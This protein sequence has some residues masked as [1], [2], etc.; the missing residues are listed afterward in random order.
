MV[1][2]DITIVANNNEPSKDKNLYQ[3]LVKRSMMTEHIKRTHTKYGT[4]LDSKIKLSKMFV[5]F[6]HRNPE[7]VDNYYF[8][9]KYYEK[10]YNE[11][12]NNLEWQDH[13][14]KKMREHI[15]YQLS[16]TYHLYPINKVLSK[17]FIQR[18]YECFVTKNNSKWGQLKDKGAT[19]G[20]QT[21]RDYFF[22]LY[23]KFIKKLRN[24]N[25]KV[26]E[27][28]K[29]M[30]PL[31]IKNLIKEDITSYELDISGPLKLPKM[32]PKELAELFVKRNPDLNVSVED[33]YEVYRQVSVLNNKEFRVEG[34]KSDNQDQDQCKP[35]ARIGK[36]IK[37]LKRKWTEAK[38]K[39]DELE[40]YNRMYKP[41][42]L[43]GDTTQEEDTIEKDPL[44]GEPEQYSGAESVKENDEIDG[45]KPVEKGVENKSKTWDRN[46]RGFLTAW[47]MIAKYVKDH[48]NC[49]ELK[50][51]KL[52]KHF[53][54][55]H[56]FVAGL[57]TSFFWL[58]LTDFH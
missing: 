12:K 28:Y 55:K 35:I 50:L 48:P 29:N 56:P 17:E 47:D 44:G 32:T 49:N 34:G 22:E 36:G 11:L 27:D 18:M 6:N 38:A 43:E 9:K 19:M 15:N 10:L 57:S 3:N 42:F 31:M 51:K 5:D 1:S 2:S 4:N 39:V 30:T 16:T 45:A 14:K 53:M 33:Y 26:K 7:L 8:D 46:N 24:E 23:Y 40:Q 25:S 13:V 21:P 54:E 20:G 37:T 58:L 41:N 52:F